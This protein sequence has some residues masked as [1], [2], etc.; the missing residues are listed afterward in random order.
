MIDIPELGSNLVL[1]SAIV[2]SVVPALVAMVN[3]RGWS[4]E[5]KAVVAAIIS[6]AVGAGTVFVAGEADRRD[7]LRSVLIVFF[8]GQIAYAQFW[9]PS[10]ITDAIERE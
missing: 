2:A 9:K 8:L 1:Y 10:R 6:V 5:A 3:R 7:N 4:S